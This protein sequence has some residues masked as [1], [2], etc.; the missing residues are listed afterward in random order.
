MHC[1]LIFC[2]QICG[3]P[4]CF[5][6][7]NRMDKN[8][9]R[10][11]LVVEYKCNPILCIMSIVPLFF[12]CDNENIHRRRIPEIWH[13][14]QYIVKNP[15][16]KLIF[17]CLYIRTYRIGGVAVG[18]TPRVK[19]KTLKLVFDAWIKV[20]RV[21]TGWFGI[22]IMCPTEATCKI[23]NNCFTLKSNLEHWSYTKRTSSS[24]HGM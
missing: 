20:V 14:W 3:I 18:C 7:L 19:S 4:R 10:S 11:T 23:L 24:S 15:E 22:R 17:L 16:L 8:C 13:F 1:V 5:F 9:H 6:S 12:T 21:K 2:V